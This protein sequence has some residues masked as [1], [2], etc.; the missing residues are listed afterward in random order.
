M[1]DDLLSISDEYMQVVGRAPGAVPQNGLNWSD[2]FKKKFLSPRERSGKKRRQE[3]PLE[4]HDR[5]IAISW[6]IYL[7]VA[8]C[9]PPVWD[10]SVFDCGVG[11][12]I[13]KW[14]SPPK[15]KKFIS[16]FLTLGLISILDRGNF[17]SRQC[18]SHST[19]KG[20]GS[21]LG[22]ILEAAQTTSPH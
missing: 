12:T 19:E 14:G 2:F 4:P 17:D 13:W 6:E 1:S 21:I 11:E 15:T 8:S 16:F 20:G 7:N 5:S 3:K 10:V 18:P 9:P 22:Y